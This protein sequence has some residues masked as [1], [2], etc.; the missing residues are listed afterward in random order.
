MPV[1][2]LLAAYCLFVSLS[3]FVLAFLLSRLDSPRPELRFAATATGVLAV[4]FWV[5]ALLVWRRATS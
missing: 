5:F 1:P 4:L 2:P 3:L